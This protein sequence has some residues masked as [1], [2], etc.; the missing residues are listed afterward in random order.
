MWHKIAS[1]ARGHVFRKSFKQVKNLIKFLWDLISDYK[2]IG[3]NSNVLQQT[4]CLMVNP[5]TVDN[6]A[7]LL[8]CTPAG[9]T[10]DIKAV[11]A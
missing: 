1:N 2:K 3:Y 9:R 6:S 7:F 5:I 10:S 4:A 11:P 8:N